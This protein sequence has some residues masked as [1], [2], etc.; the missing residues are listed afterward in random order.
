MVIPLVIVSQND[1]RIL[2]CIELLPS[3]QIPTYLAYKITWIIIFYGNVTESVPKLLH[4][5]G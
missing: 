5:A 4:V 1:S 2:G 3:L